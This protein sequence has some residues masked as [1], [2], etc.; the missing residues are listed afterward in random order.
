LVQ[1]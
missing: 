1:S